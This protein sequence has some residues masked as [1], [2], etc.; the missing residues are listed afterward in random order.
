MFEPAGGVFG[1]AVK[2]TL[3]W[4][5]IVFSE[6]RGIRATGQKAL[7]EGA[8]MFPFEGFSEI[9]QG[10][11]AISYFPPHLFFSNVVK[12]VAHN[13]AWFIAEPDYIPARDQGR[14]AYNIP[15]LA[16][17]PHAM[18]KSNQLLVLSG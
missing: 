14:G 2:R 15:L 5:K 6:R 13:G 10:L 16:E 17:I 11:L 4:S 12:D 3:E 7:S 9:G 1:F 8:M 18:A